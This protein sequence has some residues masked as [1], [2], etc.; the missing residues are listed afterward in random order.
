MQ[1]L[2]ECEKECLKEGT[3]FMKTF[4]RALSAAT[5]STEPV[6]HVATNAKRLLVQ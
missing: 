4:Q 3:W 1:E 5:N 6:K 2:S